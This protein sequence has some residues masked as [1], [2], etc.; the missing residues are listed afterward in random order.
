LHPDSQN[1][2]PRNDPKITSSIEVE[3]AVLRGDFRPHL[4]EI[5]TTKSWSA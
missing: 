4:W 1:S 5:E 3:S 2:N